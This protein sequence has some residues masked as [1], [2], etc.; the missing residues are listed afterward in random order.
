MIQPVI[1]GMPD[2]EQPARFND[3]D[4]PQWRLQVQEAARRA[5]AEAP[6]EDVIAGAVALLSGPR[7][8][9]AWLRARATGQIPSSGVSLPLDISSAFDTI[10]RHL[11]RAVRKR[12][13]HC[14]FPGCDMPAAGCEVH[15]ITRRADGGRPR[16]DQPG[17]AVPVPPPPRHPPLGLDLHPASRRHHHRRQPRRHQNPAQPPPPASR[18]T[19]CGMTL[20]AR[21]GTRHRVEHS[22]PDSPFWPGCCSGICE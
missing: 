5:A 18:L 8:R 7:G 14:R 3:P 4:H 21:T 20:Q 1:T 12:D 17:A 10:P 19:A 11:R 16:P 9:A 13:K 22:R 2:Y 15:H 6:W